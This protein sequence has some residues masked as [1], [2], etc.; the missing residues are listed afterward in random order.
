MPLIDEFVNLWGLIEDFQFDSQTSVE[1]TIV[2]T[3][4]SNGEYSAKSAY[5]LQFDG[6]IISSYPKLVW[7]VWVPSKCKFFMW[8]LY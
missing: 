3:R 2:W 1:D 4:T 7:K 5:D 6:G 8:L